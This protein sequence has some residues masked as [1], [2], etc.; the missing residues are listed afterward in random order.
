MSTPVPATSNGASAEQPVGP[1]T[2]PLAIGQIMARSGLFPDITRVS[3][4]VVKVL[5]GRE[6]GIG[7]FAAMSDIHIIDGT[8]VVGARILAALVRQSPVYDYEIV[9]WTNERCSIDVYR[10]GHK[11]EPTVTFTEED[12]RLAGLNQPTRS[13]KPSNHM[14]F[15]RNMKFARAM[16]NGVGLHCPDLT[17]G[18]AVYTPDELGV[19]DP[20][21]DV[22]PVGGRE[23]EPV[24]DSAFG[25]Q[26]D[27]DVVAERL[28]PLTE[29]AEECS[30]TTDTVVELC[31]FYYDQADLEALSAVQVA[32]MA[33][34]IRYAHGVGLDDAKLGLL[35]AR[36]M[37]MEDRAKATQAA[38]VWLTTRGRTV[39]SD[40]QPAREP[41]AVLEPPHALHA[42]VAPRARPRPS[43]TGGR[44]IFSDANPTA[45]PA[46][47]SASE[48]SVNDAWRRSR[49]TT[50]LLRPERRRHGRRRYTPRSRPARRRGN[51]VPNPQSS[52]PHPRGT[53]R[54]RPTP[55]HR[56]RLRVRVGRA[57]SPPART[58]QHCGLATDRGPPRGHPSCTMRP[59]H[60]VD[61]CP[62]SQPGSPSFA[63]DQLPCRQRRGALRSARGSRR[64]S[65]P[66]AAQAQ[67]P[68]PQARRLQLR[69]D[70]RATW[71][72]VADGQPTAHARA[73]SAAT[74]EDHGRHLS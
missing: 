28:R 16:S 18:A 31:R 45:V 41:T 23:D 34:R 7:P 8:P 12:A 48:L 54:Q 55:G 60:H 26:E 10:H 56:G 58:H 29:A 70:R 39:E 14:K 5:A 22:D 46:G 40:R 30:I 36:G 9:E 43:H 62:R 49:G 50:R 4:A 42:I 57:A 66:P 63:I 1:I 32:E 47:D 24:A 67:L 59:R 33:D 61:E 17:A 27:A 71:R 20:D 74:R 3:Q 68:D 53:R 65:G 51:P 72:L 73:A 35:A 13:G 38:D 25:G 44:P 19:Q 52:A 21:A 15:P 69:R 11:L 37:A 64:G 6:L 2:D